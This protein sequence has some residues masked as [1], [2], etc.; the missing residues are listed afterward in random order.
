[1]RKFKQTAVRE[2]AGCSE[3]IGAPKVW[4]LNPLTTSLLRVQGQSMNP[5]ICD[6]NILAADYSQNDRTQLL[7]KIVIAWN[8]NKGLTVSRLQRY[9]TIEVL[10]SENSEY[11]SVVL[12]NNWKIVA[13]VLYW[14]GQ[15]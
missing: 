4:N 11:E 14:I 13:K 6:G 12:D 1:M 10:Q 5:L 2:R 8:K 7:G 15:D 9:G 3:M